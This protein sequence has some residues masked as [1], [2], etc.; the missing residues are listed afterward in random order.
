[1]FMPLLCLLQAWVDDF[2]GFRDYG[3]L[4]NRRRKRELFWTEQVTVIH[5]NDCDVVE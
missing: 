5:V 1:M 2:W 4:E 3:A